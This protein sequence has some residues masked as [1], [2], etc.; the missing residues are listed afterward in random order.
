MKLP[1]ARTWEIDH[2]KAGASI[3]ALRTGKGMSLR[4][5]SLKMGYR[6]PAFLSDLERGRRNWTEERF[7]KAVKLLS[8]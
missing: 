1:T 6:N 8:K 3:R 7:A 2:V 4:T 5:L